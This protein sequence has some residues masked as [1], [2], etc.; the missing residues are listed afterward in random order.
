MVRKL[1]LRNQVPIVIKYMYC[2]Y[3]ALLPGK[4]TQMLPQYEIQVS[5]NKNC[6]GPL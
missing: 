1:L 3:M 2:I 4:Y 5:T 6:H